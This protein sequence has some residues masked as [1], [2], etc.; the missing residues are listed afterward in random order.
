MKFDYS[1]IIQAL[2]EEALSQEAALPIRNE[3]CRSLFFFHPHPTP[4]VLL[5]FHGFTAGPYQFA[6]I[7]HTLFQD[8]YNVVVPL[9]PGHGVAGRWNAQNP[10]PLPQS[11]GPY[12][13]FAVR[14]LKR[15][16]VLGR[17]L[18]VGGVG[19]GATLGAW[20]SLAYPSQIDRTLLLAP[21]WADSL[22]TIQLFLQPSSPARPLAVVGS[23]PGPASTAPGVAQ[24][25][26]EPKEP[27]YQ[28]VA[29]R[30]SIP[31]SC[32]SGFT[33]S[34]LKLLCDL[35]STVVTQA[36]QGEAPPVLLV[37]SES[38]RAL[39]GAL[40]QPFLQHLSHHGSP[41]WHLK[42]NRVLDLAHAT[43][44]QWEEN[45]YEMQLIKLMKHFIRLDV[46]QAA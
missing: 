29:P 18:I 27:Y 35:G 40:G 3:Q 26:K 8:G 5:L 45:N 21:Y 41:V 44:M 12:Q 34:S 19:G 23:A 15:S 43:M 2:A 20:L 36:A 4:K 7:A 28:W 10:P 33:E 39:G 25:A 32:Y 13:D 31:L 1:Q 11:L 24:G 46:L 6:R 37:T 16:R 22:P 38:D 9:L 17:Q 14:W 30:H 42:F